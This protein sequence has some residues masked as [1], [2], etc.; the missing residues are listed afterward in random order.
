M[1][2]YLE[3]LLFHR[4]LNLRG[5]AFR[6][7]GCDHAQVGGVEEQADRGGGQ[8]RRIHDHFAARGPAHDLVRMAEKAEKARRADTYPDD[9]LHRIDRIG[10]RGGNGGQRQRHHDDHLHAP[11]DTAATVTPGAA[12]RPDISSTGA[13]DHVTIVLC[14]PRT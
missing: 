7:F 2:P 9:A 14:A 13:C 1:P 6:L 11:S 5:I 4:L 10:G 12:R 8:I 3:N